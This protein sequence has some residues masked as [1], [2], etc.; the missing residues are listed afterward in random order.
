MYFTSKLDK[1]SIYLITAVYKHNILG[2]GDAEGGIDYKERSHVASSDDGFNQGNR[3]KIT[4]ASGISR[5]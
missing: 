4:R 3:K 1:A 5:R 2:S